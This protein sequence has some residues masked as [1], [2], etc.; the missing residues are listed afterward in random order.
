MKHIILTLFLIIATATLH[1]YDLYPQA[2]PKH[3]FILSTNFAQVSWTEGFSAYL[4]E[5]TIDYVQPFYIPLS[6]GFFLK[7]PNPNLKSFGLR[8]AYHINTNIKPLDLYLAYVFDFGFLRNQTL[9]AH[10]DTP[11]VPRF[12][13][14]R[15]GIRYEF[16]AIGLYIETGFKLQ[17]LNLG[18]S[19]RF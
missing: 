16:R 5:F 8:V 11:V 18:I 2:A 9:S 17:S 15:A 14:F 12:W 19:L 7:T 6:V 10:G 3:A 4:P 1:A 13:D